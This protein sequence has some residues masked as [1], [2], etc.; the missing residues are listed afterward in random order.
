MDGR[1][2]SE[3]TLGWVTLATAGRETVLISK[4]K[5]L[6]DFNWTSQLSLSLSQG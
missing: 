2:E 5:S 4:P 3:V 1:S 6:Y